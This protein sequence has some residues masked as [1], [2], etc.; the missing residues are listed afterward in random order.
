[1]TSGFIHLSE[2]TA[3]NEPLGDGILDSES[4]HRGDGKVLFMNLSKPS[5]F[6]SGDD[7]P[8]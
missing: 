1:M 4:D 5:A 6:W 3:K 7:L 8:A 2:K